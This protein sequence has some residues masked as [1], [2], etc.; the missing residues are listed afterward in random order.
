MVFASATTGFKQDV[1]EIQNAFLEDPVMV[2]VLERL[3]PGDVLKEIT[4]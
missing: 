3:L 1:P 2:S 4:P